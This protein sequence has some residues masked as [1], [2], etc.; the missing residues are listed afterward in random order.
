ME[1][2]RFTYQAGDQVSVVRNESTQCKDCQFAAEQAGLCQKLGLKPVE[3]LMGQTPCPHFQ[4]QVE[5]DFTGLM[6]DRDGGQCETLHIPQCVGCDHNLGGDLCAYL[7]RKPAICMEN[8]Q[9]CPCR[10]PI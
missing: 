9:E 3:Y 10:K 5:L 7:A 2:H 8:L 1:E 6:S 4:G